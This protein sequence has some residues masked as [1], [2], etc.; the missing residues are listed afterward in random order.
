[1]HHVHSLLYY[2]CFTPFIF[3]LCHISFN[4][5]LFMHVRWKHTLRGTNLVKKMYYFQNKFNIILGVGFTF[6][7]YVAF[8]VQQI[9]WIFDTLHVTFQRRIFFQDYY[10]FSHTFTCLNE[11]LHPYVSC[12]IV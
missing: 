7:F 6:F 12:E 8:W 5:C 4:S 3:P 2:F 1:M 10:Y 9:K 11:K